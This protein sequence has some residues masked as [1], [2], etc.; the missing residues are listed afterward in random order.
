MTVLRDA[1]TNDCG[2][3]TNSDDCDQ[4]LGEVDTEYKEVVLKDDVIW[5]INHRIE[6]IKDRKGPIYE[7]IREMLQ[8]MKESAERMPVYWHEFIVEKEK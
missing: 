1:C 8:S 4:Y 6:I 5:M 3:C 2:M 7:A